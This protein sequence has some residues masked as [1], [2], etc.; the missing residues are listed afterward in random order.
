MSCG[1][2][3][4][5]SKGSDNLQPTNFERFRRLAEYLSLDE[6]NAL[7]ELDRSEAPRGSNSLALR[8][9]SL[10]F[11]E[12]SRGRLTLTPAGRGVLASMPAGRTPA[13]P[14]WSRSGA[15]TELAGAVPPQKSQT[16]RVII[17]LECGRAYKALK[18]HLAMVHGIS[19]DTYRARWKL[20][21]DYPLVAPVHSRKRRF[22]A[23]QTRLWH[24][25]RRKTLKPSGLRSTLR[26]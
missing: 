26:S 4:G 2:A 18:R 8:L 6:R 17:C 7:T 21:H 9:I 15:G 16:D 12:L 23:K 1:S 19:P 24:V 11:A 14:G 20:P 10:G 13:D 3:R 25:A 5:G 22:L